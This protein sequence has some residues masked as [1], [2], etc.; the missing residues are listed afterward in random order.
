MCEHINMNRTTAIFLRNVK[1]RVLDFCRRC[2]GIIVLVVRSCSV[3]Q[4]SSAVKHFTLFQFGYDWIFS[5]WENGKQG[6]FFHAEGV[7]CIALPTCDLLHQ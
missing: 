1:T 7:I 4:Q 3:G 2:D 6:Q 5:D